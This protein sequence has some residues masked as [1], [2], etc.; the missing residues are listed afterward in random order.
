MDPVTSWFVL[1]AI[2]GAVLVVFGVFAAAFGV[3][4]RPGFDGRLDR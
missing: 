3:D 1:P 4:T 2:V